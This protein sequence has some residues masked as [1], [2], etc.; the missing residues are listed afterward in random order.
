MVPTFCH[1]SDPDQLVFRAAETDGFA[2]FDGGA[3]VC[4]RV[5]GM[6]VVVMVVVMC[7]GEE[8]ARIHRLRVDRIGARHIQRDGIKRGKHADVRHDRRITVRVAVAAWR[9][10][11]RQCNVEVR[12]SVAYG[13]GVLG[14]FAVE[15]VVCT[16]GRIDGLHRTYAHAAATAGTFR[17]K[18]RA[19]AVFDTRRAMCAVLNALAAA[20][21]ARLT[22]ARLA[23][24]VHVHFTGAGAGAHAE[25]FQRAAKAG[26]DMPFCVAERND[27]ICVHDCTANLRCAQ[28]FA[29]AD[30][31]EIVIRSLDAVGNDALYAGLQGRVTIQHC[32]V[33]MVERIGTAADIQ[34]VAVG[35]KRLAAKLLDVVA[36]DLRPVWTQI[37]HVARLAEMNLYRDVF[38][39]E[40]DLLKAGFLHQALE[41]V[42]R[43]EIVRAQ[44]RE[45]DLRFFHSIKVPPFRQ[46]M[47]F[48]IAAF[49][50]SIDC[51]SPVSTA[52]V[53]QCSM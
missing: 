9:D 23:G 22:H 47:N 24:T 27:D 48:S 30:R 6:E 32:A 37:G 50:S 42:E 19:L 33:E 31:Y 34:R 14:D 35:Q 43:A 53:R 3:P 10:V 41:L 38:A 16:V 15:H 29:A 2:V 28:I 18:D 39:L 46:D 40:I 1:F 7:V 17:L 49:R 26:G 52:S 20:D 25:V 36:H 8:A 5:H 11:Q 21:A 45:I 51:W 4:V 12:A 13:L 44:I